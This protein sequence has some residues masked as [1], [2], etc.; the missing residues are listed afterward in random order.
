MLLR[1]SFPLDPKQFFSQRPVDD[2]A[3]HPG[4]HQAIQIAFDIVI[5]N[6]ID[7]HRHDTSSGGN[8]FE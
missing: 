7:L 5:E 3:A 6:E 2:P 8:D 4:L 1:Q